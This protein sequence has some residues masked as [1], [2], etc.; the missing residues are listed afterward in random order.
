MREIKFQ[1]LYKGVP[2]SGDNPAFAWHKK[3]YTIGQLIEKPL[4]KLSDV[5]GICDL[6]AERQYTG[7]KDK[8]GV[9]IYEGDI[10]G[11]PHFKDAAGRDHILKHQVVW[12][13]KFHGWFLLN[14]KSQDEDNGSL[15]LFVSRNGEVEVIGNIYEDGNLLK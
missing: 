13:K 7:L 11:S 8:N 3:T 14:C 2:Y 6:I 4:S 5:H 15:Q 10:I 1:F 9:E 12:S